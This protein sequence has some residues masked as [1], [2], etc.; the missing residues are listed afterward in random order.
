MKKV[1]LS[2]A[3]VALIASLTVACSNKE[4]Q[5]SETQYQEQAPTTTG[6]GAEDGTSG[7][8]GEAANGNTGG[9]TG[10]EAEAEVTVLIDENAMFNTP[11]LRV[12]KGTT[13]TWVNNDDIAHN[14][15]EMNDLFRSEDM[16]QGSSFSYTFDQ[17]GT[18][19]YVC[20]FHPSMEATVIVEE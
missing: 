15:Y 13:V 11:E 19:S 14:V 10:G 8:S 16:V 18:Y 5:P 17:P 6:T 1:L 12:K 20:S 2:V 7:N 9:T 4:A 3:S